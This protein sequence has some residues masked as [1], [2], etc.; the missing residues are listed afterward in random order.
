MLTRIEYSR[1]IS[2]S[3][4]PSSRLIG[5]HSHGPSKQTLCFNVAAFLAGESVITAS[6]IIKR[7][8]LSWWGGETGKGFH[9][10][11]ILL[12]SVHRRTC[13]SEKLS[14]GPILVHVVLVKYVLSGS[15]A[16][17]CTGQFSRLLEESSPLCGSLT[18]DT[19]PLIEMEAELY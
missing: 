18:G 10:G 15:S 14:R 2:I 4:T 19:V 9:H 17:Y 1:I 11:V 7:R 5:I 13:E 8:S 12:N 3:P 6:T 16:W